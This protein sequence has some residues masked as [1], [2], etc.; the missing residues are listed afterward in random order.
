MSETC[1]V[2]N[3]Q[4]EKAALLRAAFA[5]KGLTKEERANVLGV[6][7]RHV[8][9]YEKGETPLRPEVLEKAQEATGVPAWFFELGFTVTP[10]PEAPSVAERV[11]AIEYKVASITDMDRRIREMAAQL[12]ELDAEVA[13]LRR[14]GR[15]EDDEGKRRNPGDQG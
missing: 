14:R 2:P 8:S 10:E 6:G 7:Q 12:V 4:S 3:D 15:G 11:E 9:R 1:R 5:Y 13:A